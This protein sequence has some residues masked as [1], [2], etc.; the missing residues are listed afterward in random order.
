MLILGSPRRLRFRRLGSPAPAYQWQFDSTN[1]AGQTNAQLTVAITQ[2]NQSG[3]RS[4]IFTDMVGGTNVPTILN[5][6]PKPALVIT[7]VMS[8]EAK[9]VKGSPITTFGLVGV[10]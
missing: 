7:E 2:T 6:T 3:V 8:S 10:E 5:V 1:L 4:V 9:R